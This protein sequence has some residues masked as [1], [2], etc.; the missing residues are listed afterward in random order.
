[1][2]EAPLI[3]AEATGG[4]RVASGLEFRGLT[5]L[6]GPLAF[7]RGVPGAAYHE[8]VDVLAPDGT[9][10]AGRVLAVSGDVATIEVFG[11][12]DGLSL[13]RTSVRFAGHPLTLGVG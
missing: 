3:D 10:I 13:Q 12:T 1:M 5:A 9:K 8:H 6:R 7:V 2:A 11:P 4:A